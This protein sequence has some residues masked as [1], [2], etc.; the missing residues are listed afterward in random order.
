VKAESDF[1][2][3]R[4]QPGAELQWLRNDAVALVR[5]ASSREFQGRWVV[6]LE[7]VTSMNEAEALRGLEFRVAIADRKALEAGAY[8]VHDLEG[9]AVV[10]ASGEDV[11][12]VTGVQF[13]SGAPLLAITD[14]RGDEVLV[15]MVEGICR[16]V[17]PAGKRIVIDPPAGLIEVNR[18]RRKPDVRADGD[19]ERS[20]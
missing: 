4:F 11:G 20:R 9:C 19:V 8:Y 2:H 7:G 12:R 5:V 10:T 16:T 13:G 6:S 14:A 15:P 3:E 18:T 1:A 17:D